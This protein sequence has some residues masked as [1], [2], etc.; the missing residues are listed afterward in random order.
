MLTQ[1]STIASFFRSREASGASTTIPSHGKCFT[2]AVGGPEQLLV[3]RTG[4]C[5]QS[6]NVRQILGLMLDK[7]SS[8]NS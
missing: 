6:I 4:S 8:A 2:P 5:D 3:L 1:T 7:R